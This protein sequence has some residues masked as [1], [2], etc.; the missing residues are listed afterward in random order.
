MGLMAGPGLSAATS[1]AA[2]WAAWAR[3]AAN[4]APASSKATVQTTRDAFP[5]VTTDRGLPVFMV[6]PCRYCGLRRLRTSIVG[7]RLGNVKH[8]VHNAQ[9]AVRSCQIQAP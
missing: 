8:A 6:A 4:S 2:S 3:G 1:M 9:Y 7:G 5:L